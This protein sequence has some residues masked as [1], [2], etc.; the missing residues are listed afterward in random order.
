MI[1]LDNAATTFPKPERVYTALETANRELSFNAGRGSYKAARAA[2]AIIDDTKN[3]L[4]SLFHATGYA[5]IVFTPSVTHALNQVLNGLDLT[6]N[7]VIY[8]SPYEHN[9]VARTV[10]QLSVNSGASVKMLPLTKDLQIDLEKA[11]YQFSINSPSVV[12]LNALSNVTGYILPVA[13]IFLMAKEYGAITVLDAAQAAGLIDLD[14]PALNADVLCFAGHKTLMGPFGIGGFLI[15]HGITLKNGFD[16]NFESI[17]TFCSWKDQSQIDAVA[18]AER[19]FDNNWIDNTKKLKVVPFPD[20]IIDKLLNFRKSTVD[21]TTDE[22]EYGYR[23]YIKKNAKFHMPD[24]VKMRGYQDTA[25]D[26]WFKQH[27]KGIYSMCTGAGKTFTALAAMVRLA[28]QLNDKLAV[29]IVC[30]YIHLVSQWEEDVIEWAPI[31]II[32]HSKSTTPRWEDR[33]KQACR[34]FRK[35][36]APFVCI[37][38]N[39]TFSGPKVQ[40]YVTK[41]TEDDNILFIVDEAHNFGSETLSSIMPEQFKY[42]IALSA[43]IERHM[44]RAGTARLFRFFGDEVINYGLEDAIRDKALV[45]YDYFP[46]PVYLQNDELNTYQQLTRELKKYLIQKNGKLRVSEAGKFIVY[47]R[48]RLLAG[49][50][51]KVA[52]L[53]ELMGD[54]RDKKNILV[55]CGATMAED[56]DSGE[57]SRQIDLVTQKLRSEYGMSVQRFTAEEDLKER[58]NIKEY[59]QDGLYQVITAIKCLDEGVNIP[60]IQTAFILSSSRNPKEFIQRRGRL[61]RRSEG[62]NKAVIYDFVTLPRD[63]DD[64][65]PT[66][67]N[68]D[69]SII[70]GELS[71]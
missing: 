10:Y 9:A 40:P 14:T 39:D 61:L 18:E 2:S 29:F 55:Y 5:D 48:T 24:Y 36:G 32:A 46:I 8:V 58:Q 20:I 7:S 21:Y 22:R 3:R 60:G 47:Q 37:T 34:R 26:Q 42:R 62:K 1:Y 12:I 64:V 27:C 44:D 68:E 53:M 66:N 38:T 56:E 41:F 6:G 63:L 25:N 19:D 35:E 49:A 54:Y 43:T 28:E 30:P 33:L 16:E 4:L 59:F 57:E 70:L 17:Y 23:S 11:K 45:P 15:K 65:L 13:E 67:Y 52:L 51:G 71:T 69:K 50:R 31:P